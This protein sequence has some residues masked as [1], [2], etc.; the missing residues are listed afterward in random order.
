MMFG[1]L[2]KQPEWLRANLGLEP[3]QAKRRGAEA[4][5]SLRL[6][7]LVFSRWCQVML[8]FERGLY[9]NPD[10]DLSRLWWDLVEKYQGLRRPEGRAEPDY[11]SKIHLVSDP[12]YYHNYMMGELFAS[13]LHHALAGH[14]GIKDPAAFAY[15]GRREVGQFLKEKVFGPGARYPWNEFVTFATGEPLTAGYYAQDFVKE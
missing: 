8:H 10:Q 2:S 6:E 13:Q 3:R 15:T 12:V 9:A 14:L 4:R 11:A 7:S 5:Q 1:R